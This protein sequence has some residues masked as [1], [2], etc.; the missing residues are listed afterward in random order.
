MTEF[1][2]QYVDLLIKQYW[3][4]PK[5]SGEI[6]AKAATWEAIRDILA[7]FPAQFDID[8]EILETELGLFGG[9][10]LGL[11]DGSV[12]GVAGQS[13]IGDRLD[14]IGKIIGLN[15]RAVGDIPDETYRLLLKV[16][17]G[18]NNASAFMVSDNRITIQDVIELAFNGEGVVTDNQDM[19]LTLSISSTTIQPEFI[20]LIVDN[21]LLPKPQAVRYDVIANLGGGTPFGYAELGQPTPTNVLGHSELVFSP[22]TGGEYAELY[23][24]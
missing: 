1:T 24:A 14:I 19:S 3:E 11:S 16:K 7:D 21:G 8:A 2:D 12:L 17:I 4:K 23:E 22:D 18:Q 20:K 13:A 9:F 6:A 10:V 5:A 15:R